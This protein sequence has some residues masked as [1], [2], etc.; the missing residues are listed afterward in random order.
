MSEEVVL[1]ETTCWIATKYASTRWIC[2]TALSNDTGVKANVS[3]GLSWPS[4]QRSAE[5]T[6]DEQ[7]KPPRLGLSAVNMHGE[8]PPQFIPPGDG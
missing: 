5:I 7:I 2:V 6:V 1:L 4:F 8:L 3:P